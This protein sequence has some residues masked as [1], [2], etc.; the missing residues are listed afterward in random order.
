M[1][2]TLER[3]DILSKAD[4]L[5]NMV[6][7]SEVG[8]EYL[9]CLYKL[10]ADREAQR[11]IKAFTQWKDLYEDVQRFGKYHPDYKRVNLGIREA[12]R[13]MDM[14]PS[15]ADFKRAETGLQSLLDE[16]SSM[17]GRSVSPFIKVPSGNPFFETGGSCGGGCGSGGSCG[18]S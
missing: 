10:R 7:E 6:L 4:A 12:K 18:C 15:I 17:I 9:L 11:K 14:H 8:E 5:A 13:E 1:L 3:V 2:A 16:I